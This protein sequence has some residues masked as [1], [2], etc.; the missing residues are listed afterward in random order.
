MRAR[1]LVLV[2]WILAAL[3]PAGAGE[4]VLR[5]AFDDPTFDYELKRT[6]GYAPVGGADLNEVLEAARGI[7]PGDGESW[8]AAWHDL[9][10]RL[11]AQ[12]EAA[13]ARGARASARSCW[14][15][16]SNY[17]RTAEFFLH[18][19]PGDPR[20]MDSWRA[21][22]ADFRRATAGLPHP[23]EALEI[24]YPGGPLPGY[25]LR[26]DASGRRRPTVLLQTG[27]DGT[28]EELYLALGGRAVQR[29]YNVLIFEGPG[30]G[31]ALR[32]RGLHFRPDWEVVVTPVVDHALGLPVVDP[33][34]LALVGFSMGGYLAPRAAAFEHRLAALV[35]NPGTMAMVP[36]G[37]SPDQW[38]E[39]RRDPDRANA[40]LWARARGDV[41]FRWL[42]ENGLF[43]TGRKTPLE[44]LEFFRTFALTP[45]EVGRIRCPTLVLAADGDHFASADQQRRLYDALAA[46]AELV[47]FGQASPARQHCQVGALLDGSE[48]ILDWLDRA[49]R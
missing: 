20:I 21:S 36:D 25:L 43:T 33:D 44:F 40:D 7:T 35:A 2:L 37:P 9:A 15:R 47:V 46:P 30:Q 11:D 45:A 32:E 27:F 18:G 14:L 23:V 39:M 31:G 3:L 42:L 29:G 34:R 22:R 16:A 4:P 28:A 48:A 13:A 19:Q 17:H 10:T 41:G 1:P 8:Y 12:G 49:L 6:L 5:L 38:E 24:P 26:P